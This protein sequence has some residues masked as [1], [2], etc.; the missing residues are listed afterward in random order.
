M[1]LVEVL[2]ITAAVIG[3]FASAFAAMEQRL[4]KRFRR[5]GALAPATAIELP[6]LRIAM[7]WRLGRLRSA[8]A[9]V[10]G[11]DG[12]SYLNEAAYL[13]L[14]KKRAILGISLVAIVIA[15]VIFVHKALQ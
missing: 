7:R 10:V 2:Q 5:E 15:G 14:R 9:V 1:R 3:V 11:E 6:R 13:A 8:G 4:V 12:R